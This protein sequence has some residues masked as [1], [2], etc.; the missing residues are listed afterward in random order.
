MDYVEGEKLADVLERE[1]RL[2]PERALS[3]T[4][5]ILEGVIAAH[6]KGIFIA[7]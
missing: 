2:P 4:I 3:V 7:I 6:D 5:A 1:E